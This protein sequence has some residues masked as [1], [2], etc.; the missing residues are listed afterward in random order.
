MLSGQLL[1]SSVGPLVGS[2]TPPSLSK[3]DL[4]E[5]LVGS[6]TVGKP[7][8]TPRMTHSPVR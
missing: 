8:G 5:H 7:S 4:A 1:S 6:V 3:R 2:M